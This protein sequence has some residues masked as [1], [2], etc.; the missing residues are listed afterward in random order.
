MEFNFKLTENEAQIVLNALTKESYSLVVDVINNI[1]K[2]ASEQI[3]VTQLENMTS[4]NK[5]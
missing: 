3:E 5:L 2:Q 4:K 1:Q